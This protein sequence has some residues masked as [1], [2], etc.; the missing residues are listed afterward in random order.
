MY[1]FLKGSLQALSQ[2]T[3][4]GK[5]STRKIYNFKNLVKS[6]IKY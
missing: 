1:P 2:T 3:Y 4:L 6:E 5:S